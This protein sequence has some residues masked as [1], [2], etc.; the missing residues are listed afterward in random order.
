MRTEEVV[1][2]IM[3]GMD[4]Y[5]KYIIA[6][7][8]LLFVVLVFWWYY[9]SSVLVSA[10][11]KYGVD[12]LG[13]KFVSG[14]RIPPFYRTVE[15]I[16]TYKGREVFLGVVFT[17]FKNEFL[18]LPHIQMRLRDAIGYNTNRLPNYTEIKKNYLIYKVRLSVLWGVFDKNYPQVFSKSYLIIA[19]EKLLATAEDVERG[20][21]VGEIFK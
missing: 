8:A 3:N 2:G 12:I 17:G 9:R 13:G 14:S 5:S 4:I 19:L 15:I 11:L 16:G 18:T 21:T 10:F 20:R 1:N 7:L 6:A